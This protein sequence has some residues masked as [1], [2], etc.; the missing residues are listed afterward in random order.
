M[1]AKR[2]PKDELLRVLKAHPERKDTW[3]ATTW[4][5]ESADEEFREAS[6]RKAFAAL[7]REHGIDRTAALRKKLRKIHQAQSRASR[8]GDRTHGRRW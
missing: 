5:Y 2:I 4:L 8:S 6:V 7:R 1:N 3:L